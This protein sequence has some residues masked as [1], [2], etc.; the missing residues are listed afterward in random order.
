MRPLPGA[1]PGVVYSHSSH[2]I[3]S[4]V[5]R[6]GRRDPALR[7]P[8]VGINL[9]DSALLVIHVNNKIKSGIRT[10]LPGHDPA[11]VI[12]LDMSYDRN[13]RI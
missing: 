7:Q 2:V 4:E 5:A 3:T 12:G 10:P 6:P 1:L 13:S 9:A 11:Y 8:L